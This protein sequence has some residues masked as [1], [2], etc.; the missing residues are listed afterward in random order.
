MTAEEFRKKL[1]TSRALAKTGFPMRATLHDVARL[2]GVSIK[3]V[4]NVIHNHPNVTKKT[5]TKVLAAIDSLSYSP[6]LTARSLRTG[7]TS[8]ISL[9]IPELRNNYFRSLPTE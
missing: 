6:N 9:V 4:S 8:M 5:S 1:I 2:A 7:R 3:T